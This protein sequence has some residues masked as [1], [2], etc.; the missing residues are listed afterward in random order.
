MRNDLSMVAAFRLLLIASFVGSGCFSSPINVC[1]YAHF[2]GF[3]YRQVFRSVAVL[4]SFL[5][6]HGDPSF[7]FSGGILIVAF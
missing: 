5:G 4:F 3:V 7:G 6:K 2:K 1:C